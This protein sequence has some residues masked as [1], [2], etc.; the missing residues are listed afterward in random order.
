M[1]K[2]NKT[3]S[4]ERLT[5]LFDM[6]VPIFARSVNPLAPWLLSLSVLMLIALV[7]VSLLEVRQ[8][9]SLPA[10]TSL[11]FASGQL[12]K[13]MTNANDLITS[14]EGGPSPNLDTAPVGT[15]G[16]RLDFVPSGINDS[17]KQAPVARSKT[18]QQFYWGVTPGLILLGALSLTAL[19]AISLL[20]VRQK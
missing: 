11:G 6:R 4:I 19:V 13:E 3:Y 7:A 1:A 12:S 16:G 18:A 15:D 9:V 17:R 5:S 14:P 20:K 10:F 2:G 8:N